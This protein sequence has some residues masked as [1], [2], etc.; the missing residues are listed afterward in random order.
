MNELVVNCDKLS[1]QLYFTSYS[2]FFFGSFLDL[3]RSVHDFHFLLYFTN[4]FLKKVYFAGR[5]DL[6]ISVA[7]TEQFPCANVQK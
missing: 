3:N 2:F 5:G 4:L 7:Q 6:I 1:C